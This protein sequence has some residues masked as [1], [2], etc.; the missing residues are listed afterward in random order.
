M[1][2]RLEILIQKQKSKSF[3]RDPRR[4]YGRTL[5]RYKNHGKSKGKT[6][7]EKCEAMVQ[8]VCDYAA[9]DGPSK[10]PKALMYQ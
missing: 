8:D 4:Y 7:W 5:K 9:S 3:T 6:F 10:P 1:F 2:I